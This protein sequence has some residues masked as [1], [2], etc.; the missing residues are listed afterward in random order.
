V[1]RCKLQQIFRQLVAHARARTY[2]AHQVAF[3]LQLLED[4]DH[5]AARYSMLCGEVAGG[6]QAHAAP[7]PASEHRTAQLV[8]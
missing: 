4:V 7:E 2:A 6:G 5:H 8:I 1:R 3:G